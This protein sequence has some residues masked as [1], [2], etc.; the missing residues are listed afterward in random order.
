MAATLIKYETVFP[1][2]GAGREERLQMLAS[3][4]RVLREQ[5]LTPLYQPIVDLRTGEIMG[6]EGLIRGP[7]D[8]P[9]HAPSTLFNVARSCGKT[10]ELEQVCR[11][12]HIDK[13]VSLGLS[14][15]L[16]L[17]ASPDALLLHARGDCAALLGPRFGSMPPENIVIELTES[18][19]TSNYQL[20]RQAA[21]D[22]RRLGLSI[23]IDDLGEGFSSLRMWSE[24]RPE[25]VKVDKYFVQGLDGDPIKRQFVRSIFE[26]AQQSRSMVIAEGIETDAELAAVRDLGIQYGQGYLLARPGLNPAS[27][28]PSATL[29]LFGAARSVHQIA[30]FAV[31]SGKCPSRPCLELMG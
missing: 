22:Y 26:I 18:D 31:A 8:S 29:R 13:F 16:F 23:A 20:L 6:Y 24:L 11:K 12:V 17:N 15:K 5:A 21:S 27:V 9:L 25:Y 30:E 14:G 3:F 2:S 19:P 1:D 10:I 7:S 4:H 28:L